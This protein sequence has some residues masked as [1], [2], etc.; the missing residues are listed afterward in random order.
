MKFY[1][2]TKK[3]FSGHWDG[4]LLKSKNGEYVFFGEFRANFG[5][6]IT[7]LNGIVINLRKDSRHT[8]ELIKSNVIEV[9]GID[10]Y[11]SEKL[12]FAFKS[13][14]NLYNE[15][16]SCYTYLYKNGKVSFNNINKGI[17]S[18]LDA[19]KNLNT[20]YKLYKG[21]K[22]KFKNTKS[23]TKPKEIDF[24]RDQVDRNISYVEYLTERI[25]RNIDYTN[26]L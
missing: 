13:S 2:Y 19:K 26:Y 15:Y 23:T 5:N 1:T 21:E 11:Y 3:D 17:L 22:L 20:N 7:K 16:Y 4:I 24:L 25:N 12:G 10:F 6:S 9:K 18:D 14:I 8:R